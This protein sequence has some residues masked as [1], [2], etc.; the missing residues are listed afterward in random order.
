[1]PEKKSFIPLLFAPANAVPLEGTKTLHRKNCDSDSPPSP[2][3]VG[4]GFQFA[5]FTRLFF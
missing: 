2:L 5:F 3:G 4:N 1:V